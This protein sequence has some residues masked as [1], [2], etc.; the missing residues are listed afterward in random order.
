MN[1]ATHNNEKTIAV[2]RRNNFDFIR[3]ILASGVIISHSFPLTGKKELLLHYSH[4]QIDLGRFAVECFFAMSGYLIFQSLERSK[5]ILNYLWKRILRL[6]PALVVLLLFTV[7]ILPFVYEG[8]NI[9]D[10]KSYW[11]YFPNVLLLYRVQYNVDGVFTHNPY[12][13]AI[14]G[15]LWSLSYEF[16]LYLFLLLLFPFKKRSGFVKAVLILT[17]TVSYL[18]L[19]FKPLFLSFL[20]DQ[21]LLTS[22]LSYKL[23]SFFLAG[24]ILSFLNFKKF[25]TLFVRMSLACILITSIFFNLYEA[26]APLALPILIIML[27]KLN[28]SPV[29]LI[30]K[31]IG[32]ISYGVY[33]YGFFI[34]QLLM[35]F[36]NLNTI[37]LMITGLFVTY[38][39]AFL[40]W[41][42]I[43]SP[44]L[45][46]KNLF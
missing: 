3:L 18:L 15:S 38:I 21:F 20:F 32:D 35:Y 31:V 28:T 30:G 11:S 6:F 36:F 16:S 22:Q 14:N 17:F 43:E 7:L 9:F 37:L 19:Q 34:Q 13:G 24:S 25:N 5:T 33:I 1:D 26:I 12:P 23:A 45:K 8:R 39:L 2:D 40:S 44:S 29:N 4:D 42:Y 46:F 10:E 41:R 27:S